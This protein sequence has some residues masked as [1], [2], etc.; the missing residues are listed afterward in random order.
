[1]DK[2][3]FDN[4]YDHE[5]SNAE[6]INNDSFLKLKTKNKH[7]EIRRKLFYLFI[8]IALTVFVAVI[9]IVVFFGLKNVEIRG[10]SKY[11]E[12]QILKAC[13]FSKADNLLALDLDKAEE[14]IKA[15]C[16]YVSDVSF[17]IVLP[18]TLIITVV[19]DAPSYCTVITFCY[20][21]I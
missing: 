10:N 3:D 19:E 17:K 9:C 16:P 15:K 13:G 12:E 14:K 18:S 4:D 11:T 7:K 8:G 2:N 21:K 20:P 5:L 6:L 1:M